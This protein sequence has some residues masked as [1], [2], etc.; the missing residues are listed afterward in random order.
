MTST[1]CDRVA[2]PPGLLAVHVYTPSNDWLAKVRLRDPLGWKVM[3]L[4]GEG[5]EKGRG[6]SVW[7]EGGGQ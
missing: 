1:S 6:S 2:T 3:E 5:E 7:R 4:A